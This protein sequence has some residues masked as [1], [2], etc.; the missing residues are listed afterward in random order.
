MLSRTPSVLML[1]ITLLAAGTASGLERGNVRNKTALARLEAESRGRAHITTNTATGTPGLIVVRDGSLDLRGNGVKARALDFFDRFGEAFGIESGARDLELESTRGDRL[2]S[3]HLRFRQKYLGLP[4]FGAEIRTHFNAADELYAV[5]GTLVPNLQLDPR[6]ALNEFEA[7]ERARRSVVK[8][9]GVDAADL[10]TSEPELMVYRTG[11]ARGVHGSSHLVWKVEVGDGADVREFVFVD[12]HDGFVVDRISGIHEIQR[13]IHHRRYPQPIWSEGDALP[14]SDST[15]SMQ[16]NSEVNELISSS[17]ETYQLFSNLTGGEYLSYD[18]LDHKMH[19]V[20]E[21]IFDPTCAE[22]INAS[23]NGRTTNFCVGLAVDD[24]IAHEWT[25]GYTGSTHNLIYAWQPGALNEA[26]SDIFGEI[27]DLLNGRGL[28][29]PDAIRSTGGCSVFFG[30]PAPEVSVTSPASITGRFDSR[31]AVFNPPAPWSVDALI[32]I[33]DDGTATTSDACEDLQAFAAG[34][35][36]LI[37]RGD[38]PFREK[39]LRAQQSGAVGVIIAN[40]DQAN[41]DSVLRMGGDLP[42]LDI[43]AVLISFN[44]GQLLKDNLAGGVRVRL[45]LDESSDN[46]VRWL[47]AEDGAAGAFRDMW[48]PNCMGDPGRVSD[49]AYYCLEDDNGGVHSNSGVPNHAFALVVDGG[50]Y[51][52]VTVEGIGLTRAAAIYWR[53]MREYQVPTTRFPDHADLLEIACNDLIG[54]TLPDLLSGHNSSEVISADHCDQIR[55]AMLATEMR[56]EP[57]QCGFDVVLEPDA[58]SL[59][60]VEVIYSETFDGPSSLSSWTLES[61]GVY[62]EY[63]TNRHWNVISAL[64]DGTV[65]GALFAINND[66]IGNCVPNNDDQSGVMTA[67]SPPISLP[68]DGGALFIRFDHYVATEKGWDGGNV[69]LSV[70]GGEFELIPTSSF[71]FNPYND[72]VIVSEVGEDQVENTNSN[73]LAGEPAFTGVNQ[74]G[75]DGN[76][77]R[78]QIE[79]SGLA[80]PGDTIRIRFEFGNDGCGG[81]RGW[82]IDALEVVSAA[83]REMS[84]LRPSRRIS[85]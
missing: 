82:Y 34:R 81:V 33:V 69:K 41:P 8:A 74:G 21:A 7:S 72:T 52:G 79:L 31:D 13:V 55:A 43:P 37:D 30:N 65:G 80:S 60:T 35:I 73:P 12:A 38:C 48:N 45:S 83:G 68:E 27:V 46:S 49:S 15:F 71:K 61:R 51:N 67:E 10:D 25:H 3:T 29:Q 28:D 75:V 17:L 32:E 64:P 5:N 24:V 70:N 54:A 53:T 40:N 36:A 22:S 42:T 11:L 58:P 76:W 4:V 66:S 6:P 20:Y 44:N 77:G 56:L 50:T 9:R 63:N 59:G 78:S 39:V 16:K 26:Y 47:V 1:S 84:V 85:P 23:W 62:R 57:S 19:A 18:G 14:F 2:G